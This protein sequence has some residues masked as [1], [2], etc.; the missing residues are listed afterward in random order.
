MAVMGRPPK[1][2]TKLKAYLE[3]K[4]AQKESVQTVADTIVYAD[5]P[6]ET[7][8]DVVLRISERFD[9]LYKCTHGATTGN[10][11]S[12]IVSG[13]GGVGKTH[14]VESILEYAKENAGVKS[15]VVHGVLTPVNLYKL[16]YRNRFA[17]CVTVLDDA[18][19]IFDEDQA[20]MV[21]KAALD[22]GKS[23]KISWL[24]EGKSLISKKDG[25]VPT[26]FIYEGT[27]IFITNLDLQKFVDVGKNKY[28]PHMQALMT[29]AMYID[30]RLHTLR[31]LSTWVR[32]MVSK[33]HILVQDGLSYQQEKDV[34]DFITENRDK[35]RNL[36]IRTALQLGAMVK[37]EG[38]NWRTMAKHIALR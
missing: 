18:D 37:M 9:I 38:E 10:V 28:V 24:A 33:N 2:P 6:K 7:D 3:A 29:R 34:L 23:R 31:D 30:L 1:D 20:L 11:R 36:S 25:E 32:H 4:A 8:E 12:L 15:E 19:S 14:T 21:L 35:L 13:A 22:S 17:N 5:D 27:M 16:L 26:D